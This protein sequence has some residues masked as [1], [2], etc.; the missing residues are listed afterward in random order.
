[1]KKAAKNAMPVDTVNVE[2][3]FIRIINTNK[4]EFNI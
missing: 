2:C 3:E 4:F 1:M